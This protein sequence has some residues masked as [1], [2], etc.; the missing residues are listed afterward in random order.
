MKK[1]LLLI[2]SLFLLSC[3]NDTVVKSK[4]GARVRLANENIVDIEI[5][6]PTIVKVAMAESDSL[7][8]IESIIV[9]RSATHSGRFRVKQL[10]DIVRI[11]TDSLIVECNSINGDVRFL[12]L[13]SSPLLADSQKELTLY[14]DSIVGRQYKI[15]QRFL[16]DDDEVI[17]GLGQHEIGDINMRG[18]RVELLQKNTRISNPIILSTKGYGLYWDNYSRTLFDD[19]KGEGLISSDVADKI[20]Y[21]FVKGAQFDNII[22]GLHSLSGGSPMLPRWAF[23]YF[24]SRNRYHTREELMGVVKRQRELAIPMDAIILDYLH[25][26]DDDGFGSM[27]FDKINFPD[28]NGMIEELHSK[29][30]CKILVSVWPSF[31][32]GNKNWAKLNERGFLLNDI[33]TFG[34]NYDAYNPAAGRMYWSMVKESYWDR[35]VDGIWFDA[36]EPEGLGDFRRGRNYL[37]ATAKYLNLYSYFDMKSIYD[38]QIKVDTNRIFIL[39]RSSFFGQQRFGTVAW[40]G[41]IA[42][43]FEALKRQIPTGLNY[44]MTALPYWNSDIG[45]YFGG[46]PTDE[47]YRELFVRWFQYGAFTPFFRAHGRRSPTENRDTP[48]EM[49]SYGAKSQKILTEYIELRYRLLPYIYTLSHRVTS[50]GYTMMRALAFDFIEDRDVYQINDQFMFGSDIL[51][52]PVAEAGATSRKVYLPKGSQWYDFKSGVCYEGGEHITADA[53]IEW[54]PLFI[55]SGA[56]LPMADVMNYSSESELTE[57]EIR[58]YPGA[59]GEFILYEDEGDNYNYQDGKYSEIRFSYNDKEGVLT[60]DSRRGCYAGMLNKRRFNI[61]VVK[62]GCGLGIDR[63]QTPTT[64]IDYSGEMVKCKI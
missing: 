26:S 13:D 47:A 31:K 41:D 37:G 14:Q 44:C 50:Q 46:D 61:V 54:M 30:N 34:W 2:T 1:I 39:A 48:N 23:G 29:Y 15:K 6:S 62:D 56:I 42:T 25:W 51:V 55:R 60:I 3:G 19:S 43:T 40:S 22:A 4:Y 33:K 24:Q 59:D 9:E 11:T 45:G 53:P 17:Y 49:W 64:V 52:C 32:E 21:Y 20:Q 7:L 63:V 35:G 12:D 5:F 8:N 18:K 36:T 57:L 27:E 38:N 10:G 28:P 58:V 16:W